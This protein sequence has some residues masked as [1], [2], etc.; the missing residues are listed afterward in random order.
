MSTDANKAL[1]RR[2]LE[3][4]WSQGQ[5]TVVD[6][7]FA[8]D[9]V[10]H[11]PLQPRFDRATVKQAMLAARTDFPDPVAT[12]ADL[13]AEGDQVV[14]RWSLNGTHQ[15]SLTPAAVTR[16]TIFRLVDG[17]LA[18]SWAE[19]LPLSAALTPAQAVG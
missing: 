14:A 18:E 19:G 11:V 16:I 17:Q 13:V 8:P 10:G 15:P 6:D 1:V 2:Y 3:A 5:V 4:A 12:V 7:L 9:Y